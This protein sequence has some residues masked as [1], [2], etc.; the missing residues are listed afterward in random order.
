M[1]DFKTIIIIATLSNFF[2]FFVSSISYIYNKDKEEIFYIGFSGLFAS[3]GLFLLLQRGVVNNF[4]SIILANYLIVFA[5]LLSVKGL[6]LFRKSKIPFIWF[7][8]LI[9]ILFP[10]LF[11]FFTYVSDDINVRTIIASLI[12]GYLY[13]KAVFVMNHKVEELIKIE[14]RIFSILPV[15]AGAVYFFRMVIIL[16]YNQN[17]NF[18]TSGIIN[19]IS[20]I[21]GIY[22]PI[23]SILGIFWCYLKIQNYKLETLALTDMLTGLYNKA[24]FIEL[25]TKLFTSQKRMVEIE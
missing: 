17:D 8:K 4:F 25:Q 19:S 20:A 6:F 2:A 12:M 5:L 23:N 13:F 1:I 21:I 10:F 22:L 14:V 16:F 11:S 7:D 3:L 18:M 24:A 9:I 15:F